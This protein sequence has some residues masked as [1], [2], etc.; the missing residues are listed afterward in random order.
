V[1]T[2]Y[3]TA[4]R[5]QQRAVDDVRVAIGAELDRLQSVEETRRAVQNAALR[6]AELAADQPMMSSFAYLARMR[7]ERLRLDGQ[8]QEIGRRIDGLRDAA[9]AAYGS[10]RAI[11]TAADGFRSDR[12]RAAAAAEQAGIDDLSGA[13]FLAA[14]NRRK[15]AGGRP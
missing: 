11:E 5:I 4:S 15:I 8:S 6:E 13:A 1:K 9:V 14:R 10:L 7:S 12:D 2:P 3:D